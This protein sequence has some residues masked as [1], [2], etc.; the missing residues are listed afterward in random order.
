MSEIIT[1]DKAEIGTMVKVCKVNGDKEVRRR[2]RDLGIIKGTEMEILRK[3]PLG[4]PVEF[5]LRNYNLS[6][7][8]TEAVLIEVERI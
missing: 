1:L 7:R 5:R 2:I 6:L 4:D 3:A 8:R